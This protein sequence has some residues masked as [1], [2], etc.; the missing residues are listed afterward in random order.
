MN[1][2][3]NRNKRRNLYDKLLQ[4]IGILTLI[5]L[6]G[7]LIILMWEI[8][9]IGLPVINANFIFGRLDLSISS[10][11]EMSTGIWFAILGSLY[12]ILLVVILSVPLG[13]GGGI[14]LEEYANKNS[15]SYKLLDILISNLNGVPS[16][17]YGL[18]GGSIFMYLNLRGTVI[19]AGVTLSLMILP[20]IVVT[21]QESL[22]TVPYSLKEAAYGLGM[23]KWQVIKAVTLPYCISS[24]ITGIILSISRAIGEAAPLI[25]VGVS[26]SISYKPQYLTDDMTALPIVINQLTASPSENGLKLAAATAVVLLVILLSLNTV[27]IIIRNKNQKKR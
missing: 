7:F 16:V 5:I 1:N 8:F 27:A 2:Q 26:A 20:V 12:S 19:A 10:I 15:K 18:L 23:T 14:Y 17:I 22:K 13:I 24:I 9:S 4:L 21:T 11:D 25:M 3:I 6:I